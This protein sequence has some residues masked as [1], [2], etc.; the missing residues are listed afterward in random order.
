METIIFKI[1]EVLKFNK[2]YKGGSEFNSIDT[3]FYNGKLIKNKTYVCLG[4]TS[5]DNTFK[6]KEVYLYENIVGKITKL[7][8]LSENEKELEIVSENKQI[9]SLTSFFKTEKKSEFSPFILHYIIV[10]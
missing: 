2:E 1:Y 4:E 6:A 3:L 7:K 8:T 9:K 10:L 5:S